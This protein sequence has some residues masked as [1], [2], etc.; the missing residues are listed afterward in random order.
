M[1]TTERGKLR[2]DTGQER[3]AAIPKIRST[4]LIDLARLFL[5]LEQPHSFPLNAAANS[6][7]L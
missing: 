2:R 7:E 6:R 5:N 4:F 3:G 1:F